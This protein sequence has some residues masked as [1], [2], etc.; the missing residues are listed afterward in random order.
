MTRTEP[1]E[2]GVNYTPREG[3][4]HSWLDLDIASV[5][6]DFEAI[7]GLGLDHVR[8]FPLWPLLQPSRGHIS[9][10]AVADLMKVVDA[11]GQA[12]LKVSVDVLNG[13]LSSYDFVPSWLS[14]WHQRNLFNDLDVISAEAQLVAELAGQL[15]TRPHAT[16][17]CLGNEFAQFAAPR[18]PQQ[19]V[20]T[21]EEADHWL[22][23]LLAEAERV[24][25]H[26]RHVHS[27]DD[28]IWFVDKHPF[29]P[30]QAVSRGSVTTVHSWIF[31]GVGP[32]YGEGHPA[33]TA[34]AR[35][36]L[37]LAQAWSP[38][39]ERPI[40]RQEIGAPITHVRPEHAQIFLE[41]TLVQVADMPTLQAVTWWCSHD[42]NRS[43][44]DFPELE[45]S[46]GLFDAQGR[47]KPI[48]EQFAEMLPDLR[49]VSP[50][51]AERPRISFRATADM[52]SL[53]APSGELFQQWLS[54]HLSGRTPSLHWEP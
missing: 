18:H 34:F 16:G 1:L 40:W 2:F 17:I 9:G 22:V 51:T 49:R 43:L 10:R 30:Q 5:T 48:A 36:L 31:G 3:W 12:G 53:T 24:F 54:E 42:V 32:L 27:F 19:S 35:Y 4:F 33:L 20:L 41:S 37:E 29:T 46:L 15:S 39:P 44:P 23:T 8:L 38:D 7:A 21:H 6:C 25:P 26:A 13:H 47:R 52:R 14:T 45:Y 11:A 28:D 50:S